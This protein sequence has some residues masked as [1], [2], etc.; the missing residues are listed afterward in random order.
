MI[1][2]KILLFVLFV[3][4]LIGCVAPQTQ[5][6]PPVDSPMADSSPT[7][8]SAAREEF[9]P[10]TLMDDDTVLQTPVRAEAMPPAEVSQIGG[11]RVQVAA[12]RDHSR[13]E[14]LREQIQRDAQVLTYIHFDEDIQ[15][16]K[17]RAGNS[18]TP[19]SAET[20]RDTI[21]AL[22]FPDAYVVRTQ[23]ANMQPQATSGFRVQIFSSSTRGSAEDAQMQARV[24][25]ARDDVFIDFESPYFKVRVGNFQTRDDAEILLREVT[26]KGYE[27]AFIVQAKSS[28]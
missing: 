20:L 19:E 21:R 15:L 18:H 28:Q 14:A 5:L 24:Q 11:F 6:V 2:K 22:G 8:S 4:F 13:A 25:L 17:I 27:T 7:D 9:D 12:L 26:K 23:I 3:V 10:Q 1:R 16:Y